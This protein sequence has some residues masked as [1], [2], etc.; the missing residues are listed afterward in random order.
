MTKREA[1]IV[2]AYTGYLLGSFTEM[3]KYIEEI[4]ERPV[5]T[6]ELGSET[7]ANLIRRA[8]KSDF[9]KIVVEKK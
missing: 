2:G 1:A 4:L 6:G 8:S 3:H 7:I 5:F 9:I